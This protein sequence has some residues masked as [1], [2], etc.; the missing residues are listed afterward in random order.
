VKHHEK[1]KEKATQA[2]PLPSVGCCI[3]QDVPRRFT[4]KCK[5]KKD[6]SK[7][8]TGEKVPDEKKGRPEALIKQ[9]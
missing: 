1:K 3:R 7:P 6:S 8:K 9:M 2:S 5:E 4:E